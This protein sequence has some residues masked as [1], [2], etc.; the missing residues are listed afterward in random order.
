MLPDGKVRR[1]LE[2]VR[3]YRERV[4]SQ[5]LLALHG[6]GLGSMGAL[7]V[8]PFD[9]GFSWEAVLACIILFLLGMCALGYLG[10]LAYN[11]WIRQRGV[12]GQVARELIPLDWNW[13]LD[14]IVIGLA[15]ALFLFQVLVMSSFYFVFGEVFGLY[16]CLLYIFLPFFWWKWGY[17]QASKSLMRL[18]SRINRNK[19]MRTAT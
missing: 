6:M 10:P 9:R 12:K 1:L 2:V 7:V 14:A 19:G 13:R 16:A 17:F 15:M 5:V 4:Q 8:T 11:S 18:H 3:K